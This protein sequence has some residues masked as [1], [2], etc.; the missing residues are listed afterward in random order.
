VKAQMKT[1]FIACVYS[2]LHFANYI[3]WKSTFVAQAGTM[4]PN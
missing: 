3:A 1:M 2:L 4:P